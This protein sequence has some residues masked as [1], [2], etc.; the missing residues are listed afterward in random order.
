MDALTRGTTNMPQAWRALRVRGD[1][2]RLFV[3]Q[4]EGLLIFADSELLSGEVGCILA[5]YGMS[6]DYHPKS[7]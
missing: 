2:L 1:Q 3:N 6:W 5:S 4:Q 7:P